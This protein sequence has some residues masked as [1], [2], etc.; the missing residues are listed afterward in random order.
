MSAEILNIMNLA[1]LLIGLAVTALTLYTNT[2]R[3]RQEYGALKA[4]GATNGHLYT[5]VVAQALINVVL[6]AMG[7]VVLVWLLGQVLSLLVPNVSLILTLASTM[8]VFIASL[9]IGIAGALMPAWQL[10]RV[11]PARV[12]RG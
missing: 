12:F 11:D 5:V 2:L 9:L 3:K 4:I 7:A 6:G 8:R 1:G 10:A